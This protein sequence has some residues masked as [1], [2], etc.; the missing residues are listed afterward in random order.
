[1]NK[2]PPRRTPRTIVMCI[3][4]SIAAAAALGTPASAMAEKWY[5]GGGGACVPS[6]AYCPGTDKRSWA[7]CLPP[8]AKAAQKSRKYRQ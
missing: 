6:P 7:S 4:L 3:R 1:M 8:A 5:V 2:E